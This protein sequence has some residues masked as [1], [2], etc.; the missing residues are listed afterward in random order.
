MTE[1]KYIIIDFMDIPTPVLFSNL[2]THKHIAKCINVEVISAG[3]CKV[4]SHN[5]EVQCWGKSISLNIISHPEEDAE[6]IC[7]QLIEP[8]LT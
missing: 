2:I 4:E 3:F 5:G 1:M 7:K 6:I 8:Y